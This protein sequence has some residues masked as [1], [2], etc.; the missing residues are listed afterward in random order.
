L[1]TFPIIGTFS[2]DVFHRVDI[3]L[4]YT[5]QTFGV[6]LD[7]STLASNLTFCGTNGACT[8]ANVASF[9]DGFFDTFGGFQSTGYMD[10]FSIASVDAV[11]ESSTWGMMIL[12][13]AGVGFM[14]YRRRNKIAMLRVA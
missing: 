2:N 3:L 10:N 9:G 5:T 12:G 4:N 14:A 7:G 1:G 8:G 11:P 13:F 6:K